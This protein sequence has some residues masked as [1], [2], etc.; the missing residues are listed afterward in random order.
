[1]LKSVQTEWDI[2]QI[3]KGNTLQNI[4]KEINFKFENF[5]GKYLLI[6]MWISGISNIKKMTTISSEKS[7]W[8]WKYRKNFVR[9][10]KKKKLHTWKQIYE[11]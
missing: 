2:S 5:S 1:M 9:N 8:K 7:C 10:Q 4:F 3:K 11:W 6:N